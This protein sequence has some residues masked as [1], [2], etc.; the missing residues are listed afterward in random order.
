MRRIAVRNREAA[1]NSL[2][3][4]VATAKLYYHIIKQK[5]HVN[6]IFVYR[7]NSDTGAQILTDER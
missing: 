6:H 4:I 1:L 5:H 3:N 2:D 7:F